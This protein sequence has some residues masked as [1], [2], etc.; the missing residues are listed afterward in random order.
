MHTAFARRIVFNVTT[1][2][3]RSVD[4]SNVNGRAQKHRDALRS[5]GLRSVQIWVSIRV[6][7]ASQKIAAAKMK[8]CAQ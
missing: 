8:T 3:E 2:R 6:A 1:L 7:S 5:A 4:T